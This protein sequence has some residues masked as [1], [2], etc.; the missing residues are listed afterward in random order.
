MRIYRVTCKRNN[1][2]RCYNNGQDVLYTAENED[3]A[4]KQF[5]QEFEVDAS[6]QRLIHISP[7]LRVS[8]YH[9][10]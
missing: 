8:R 6:P 3:D 7:L 10:L 1:E 9:N 2:R 4:L 5:L